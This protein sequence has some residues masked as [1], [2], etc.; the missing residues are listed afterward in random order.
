MATFQ[1]Q[2]NVCF[3]SNRASRCGVRPSTPHFSG[4]REPCIW[5]LL[6]S[7]GKSLFKRPVRPIRL[8][9]KANLCIVP[10]N[11]SQPPFCKGKRIGIPPFR[12]GGLGDLNFVDSTDRSVKGEGQ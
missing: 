11:P 10:L 9:L 1:K 7:L 4:F 5:A 3:L 6:T 2:K 12:K 8:K